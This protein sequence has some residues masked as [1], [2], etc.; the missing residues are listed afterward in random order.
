[1]HTL[2]T[3]SHLA[4]DLAK[5]GDNY[6]DNYILV[7]NIVDLNLAFGINRRLDIQDWVYTIMTSK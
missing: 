7:A 6:L 4:Y 3:N 1:M 2:L 5:Q